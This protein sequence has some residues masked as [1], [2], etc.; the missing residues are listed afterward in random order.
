MLSESV[1]MPSSS[2]Y[3][4]SYASGRK[5]I[6]SYKVTVTG[7]GIGKSY[8]TVNKSTGKI[9]VKK[10]TPKGIYTVKI[11]VTSA[12]TCTYTSA[13]KTVTVKIKVK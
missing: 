7:T 8:F 12:S 5:S 1:A 2:D 9:A 6:G 3:T 13:S 4:V 10:G 11:K